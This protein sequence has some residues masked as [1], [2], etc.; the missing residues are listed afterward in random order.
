MDG[1]L[2]ESMDEFSS[3]ESNIKSVSI[4]YGFPFIKEY[5]DQAAKGLIIIVTKNIE[6]PSNEN[7]VVFY[8]VEQEPTIDKEVWI[9]FIRKNMQPIVAEAVKNGSPA[10]NYTINVRFLVQKDG[11]LSDFIALNDPGYG[12]ARKVIEMMQ[13][14]PKWKPAE[15]NGRIVRAYHTQPITVVIPSNKH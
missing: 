6:T 15:Q 13:N 14:S 10:G 1:K 11:G 12:I 8:K 9:D 2:K 5:G 3:D 4:A 7:Q